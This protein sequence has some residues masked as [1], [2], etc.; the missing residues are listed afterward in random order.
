MFFSVRQSGSIARVKYVIY[1][2]KVHTILCNTVTINYQE[3]P[4]EHLGLYHTEDPVKHVGLRHTGDPV[5]HVGLNH[6]EDPVELVGL[7]HRGSCLTCK[8]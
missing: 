3:H 4:V 7:S 5:E 6:T 1:F 2:V 8:T